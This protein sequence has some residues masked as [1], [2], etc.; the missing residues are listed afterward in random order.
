MKKMT[1][2]E[3]EFDRKL[4]IVVA[5][6]NEPSISMLAD[7]EFLDVRRSS[8][9]AR[10]DSGF[11]DSFDASRLQG[12]S[13]TSSPPPLPPRDRSGSKGAKEASLIAPA[14]SSRTPTKEPEN[15]V[16]HL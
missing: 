13:S 10:Q 16:T 2:E 6:F 5:I 7:D 4:V 11:I 9:S 15:L 12:T 3:Y 14:K 8:S 1:D